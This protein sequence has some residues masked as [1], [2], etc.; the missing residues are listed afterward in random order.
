[1]ESMT[2][3]A[4]LTYGSNSTD[5]PEGAFY[6]VGNIDDAVKKGEEIAKELSAGS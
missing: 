2:V 5:L 4:P 3:R 6:M 1:M